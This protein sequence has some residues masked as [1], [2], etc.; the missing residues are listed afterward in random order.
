[1][2]ALALQQQPVLRMSS[3]NFI[4]AAKGSGRGWTPFA[5]GSP[6][7]RIIM[8]RM[9]NPSCAPGSFPTS[10]STKQG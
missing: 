3:V 1:V 10:P 4:S 7:S 8:K 2:Q 5:A 6:G 9:A